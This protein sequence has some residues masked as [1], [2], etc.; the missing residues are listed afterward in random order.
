MPTYNGGPGNDVIFGSDL[1]DSIFGNDGFDTLYGETGNDTLYGGAGD[2]TLIG[3]I[4]ADF[5][6]GGNGS[7]GMLGGDDDDTLHGEAGNDVLYGDAGDDYLAGG[8]GADFMSGG[9]GN[10]TYYADLGDIVVENDNEGIDTIQSDVTW[11]LNTNLE[12]LTLMGVG[13]INGTG[14]ELNNILTG[15]SAA[16]ILDGGFG[17][18]TL[19]GGAGDDIY[20]VGIGDTVV[21]A[22]NEGYD[23]VSSN[24]SF[25]L[26]ANVEDLVLLGTD[27]IN[28]TGNSLNNMLAGLFNS[29]AN[30]LTGGLGND[31][32][33]VGVGDTVVENVG[34]GV[35]RVQS[36][37]TWTL[38]ANIEDLILL[39]SIS[40]IDGTGNSLN[41]NLT[42]NSA[43]NVLTGGAGDD[44]Y[45]VSAGDTV[46]E[47]ANEGIDT[48]HS[49]VTWT[50]GAN[51]ENLTLTGIGLFNGTGNSL[52]NIL[53]GNSA[54]N[55][56]DGGLGGDTMVGGVGNDTFV[57]STGDT[58]VENVDEGVDRVQS[59]VT[60]TL[61]ANI[62]N[63]TLTGT[64]AINGTGNSLSNTLTGNSGNNRLN[65][66]A[67]EDILIG[68]AGDDIYE[69]GVGDTV[70]EQANEGTDLVIS[71]ISWTLGANV[72]NLT[73][74][75]IGPLDG[76]GNNLNNILTGNSAVNVLNG[77][78][79][80]DTLVG[81]NGDDTYL[82]DVGDTVVEQANEGFDTVYSAVTWTL[83]ANSERLFLLGN[84]AIDG[85]GNSLDNPLHGNSAAN[86]LTGGAG[87]DSYGVSLGD[88]VV[89]QANEGNDTVVS[90]VSWTLEANVE[91]LILMGPFPINGTGNSLNNKLFGQFTGTANVLTGGLG[92]DTYFVG[93]GDT[94][95]EQANEGKDSVGSEISWTLGANVEDLILM[96]SSPI[97]GTGNSLNNF[98]ASNS[99]ANVLT[100]GAGDDTYLFDFGDGI[101]TIIDTTAPGE[102]NRILFGAGIS[103]SD[104]TFTQNPLARTLTIQVGVSGADKLLFT[105]FDPTGANGSLVVQ[106]LEFA[107]GSVANIQNLLGSIPTGPTEG[108]DILTG[109]AN[110]DV[111]NAL[112]GNDVVN[113]LAGNDFIDGGAGADTMLGGVGDD[114]YVVSLGDTV[115]EMAA[116]G[117]DLVYSTISWTLD[118]N[119]EA[120][121]LFGT[122]AI[123]GT[124]NSLA[125]VLAGDENSAANVL[126]GGA[127]NDGYHVGAGDSV[128]E[129]VNEGLDI[130]QS[131]VTW[132]LGANVENL[133][134]FGTDAINGTG[135]SLSNALSGSF[136][137]AANVLTGGLGNDTYVVGVGDT[138]VEQLAEG[139]DTVQSALTYTLGANVEN[140]TL[141]GALASTGTGNALNNILTGNS[142]ANVLTGGLGDDIYY[143]G[144]GDTMVEAVNAGTDL[145][146]ST[147]SWTLG[148]NLE[149]LTLYGTGAV[150]GTGNSL[151]NIL[152]GNGAANV[153]TGGA[154]NDTLAGGLAN[155]T[156]R[157]DPGAG[158]DRISEN[159][160]TVG[161]NDRLLYGATIN[162]LDLVLS[163]QVNDLRIA[164]HGSA[165]A[166]TVQNWYSA[167]TT[168]QVETIQAGN[169]QSLLSTQ[170]DQLIQ[171]MAG[172]TQQ[173]GLTWDQAI[174]QQPQQVQAVLAAS[175]Q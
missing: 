160:G 146:Y 172:F 139:T 100:G 71:E 46:V 125:N 20:R 45:G 33:T 6:W 152:T 14:N 104:L 161:N 76:T 63:L 80:A 26:G 120:L 48:I 36:D 173:T 101:D 4:G 79:G 157:V 140:L 25:T 38:G 3:W 15:N 117:T 70:V 56:L 153:L 122:D 133:Y 112:G 39:L 85:T 60:W 31:T 96:G 74:T 21:E 88:V 43:A 159:D 108:N 163:R 115:V 84:G 111:I 65:G 171:A 1:D 12:N 47:Q 90:E 5:L 73:L 128:V 87:N 67:R 162:P 35:D 95:V 78:I 72:E 81:G 107:D 167:P 127:G 28:G 16:N 170:V 8:I 119:V 7:D 126:M 103:L 106:L 32:Y 61:G 55:V 129:N 154:G 168:A 155:D 99:G 148:A 123:N 66:G 98:L 64:G 52:N 53:T 18:D 130:V 13:T 116:E 82:V 29:A 124:G 30:V 113:A 75:G 59:D 102:T 34:E 69:V 105:N 138:V 174:N 42:G 51:V 145:V 22:A 54:A 164:I 40:A 110:D 156:Y 41:N 136:N 149:K 62:E 23:I 24:V 135:N 158:Q 151:N 131:D 142:A 137:S 147:I 9:T 132:T 83:S 2:D 118:A 169:G 89:E 141:T 77:R 150:N 143:A 97:N 134:L 92:D 91:D 109:T 58:V 94:V 165:D 166:V 57:V 44:T 114:I 50:L 19:V 11:T 10:D 144:V 37:V 175:W 86:V 121:Y 68:G 17:A 49:D 27:A 93:A